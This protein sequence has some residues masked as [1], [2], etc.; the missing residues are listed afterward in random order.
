MALYSTAPP[1]QNPEIPTDMP[2]GAKQKT[3]YWC[4]K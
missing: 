1:F 2:S 4:C 3:G